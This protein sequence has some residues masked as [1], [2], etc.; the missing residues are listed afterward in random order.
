MNP[1]ANPLAP[2]P[3]AA[4]AILVIYSI[5]LF[6][7]AITYFRILFTIV[8]NPGYV[9]GGPHFY[10]SR[11]AKTGRLSNRGRRIGS[12]GDKSGEKDTGDIEKG[13]RGSAK[14]SGRLFTG[15]IGAGRPNPETESPGLQEFYRRDV[16]VCEGDGRPIWCS[17]CM[18]WKVDRSHHCREVERC[19]KKMDHFCPWCVYLPNCAEMSMGISRH[20]RASAAY[21]RSVP[22]SAQYSLHAH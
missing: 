3:G 7:V 22:S 16:F 14:L 5:L 6:F 15:S 12:G 2:R 21:H 8:H 18:N 17:M 9:D 11:R 4:A 20:Q 19:V 13:T 1:Y 10:E